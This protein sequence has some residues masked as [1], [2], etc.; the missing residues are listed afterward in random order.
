[1]LRNPV[2]SSRQNYRTIRSIKAHGDHVFLRRVGVS[3][4]AVWPRALFPD[5]EIERVRRFVEST[6]R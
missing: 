4:V 6:S 5:E 1:M 3:P 2:E